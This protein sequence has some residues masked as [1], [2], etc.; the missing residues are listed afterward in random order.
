MADL[1]QIAD[2]V[3][4]N[5]IIEQG[6]KDG[7]FYR[8]WANGTL[9]C[10]SSLSKTVAANTVDINNY[11][12]YPFT[13]TGNLYVTIGTIAGGADLYRAHIEG[14]GS[15]YSQVRIV[16]I[17]KHTAATSMGVNIYAIGTIN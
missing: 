7:W 8:K 2:Y 15:N 4:D 10:W 5:I 11:K 3:A 1:N 6:T 16:L 9:E 12:T 14:S 17:N 13:F